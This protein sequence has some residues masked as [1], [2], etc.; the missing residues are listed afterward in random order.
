[1]AKKETS[2]EIQ[3]S[4]T[5]AELEVLQQFVLFAV[6]AELVREPY[7]EEVQGVL[8]KLEMMTT[9]KEEAKKAVSKKDVVAVKT[10]QRLPVR[11]Q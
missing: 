4:L 5:S 1:M 9:K 11:M 2:K 10:A 3:I 6:E 8:R 7:P